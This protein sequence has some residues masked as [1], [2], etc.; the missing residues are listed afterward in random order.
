MNKEAA[1]PLTYEDIKANKA[2][3]REEK[4][5]LKPTVKYRDQWWA[6]AKLRRSME[7][8]AKVDDHEWSERAQKHADKLNDDI[9]R[10]IEKREAE[11]Q[12]KG[13]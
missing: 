7:D 9:I 1:K 2:L 6:E 13:R 8:K 10:F 4:L 3:N 11:H 5:F 12:T